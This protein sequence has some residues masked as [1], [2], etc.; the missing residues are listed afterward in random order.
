MEYAQDVLWLN[1]Q[2]PASPDQT[3]GSKGDVLG[4]GEL[5]SW[6]VKVVDSGNDNPPLFSDNVSTALLIKTSTAQD[7]IIFVEPFGSLSDVP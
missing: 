3:S 5:F 7:S 6:T 4:Q 2:A 1:D